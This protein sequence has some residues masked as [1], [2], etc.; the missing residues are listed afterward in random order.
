MRKAALI[1]LLIVQCH[2]L[3][4][5]VGTWRNYMSY[6]E[7]QQIVKAGNTLFVR[8]SN[9][10][11]QYN[12]EDQSITTYDKMTGLSDTYITHIGWNQ[13]T[14]RLII[15]YQNSNI[16][17]IDR[18]GNIT[19]IA[20]LYN[21]VI[22]DDKT[23][24]SLTIDGPYA[25]LYARFGIVKVNMQRAEI[26]DTYTKQHPNYPNNLPP[27]TV[28]A[29]W[30]Q[31]IDLVKTLKPEGPKYNYF[32]EMK[33][34]QGKLYTVG[35]YFVSG[36][37]DMQRPGIVQVWDGNNWQIYQEEINNITGYQYQDNNCIDLDPTDNQ[38]VIVGSRCGIYEFQN[39]QLLKYHNQQ[40]SLLKG[41][42]DNNIMLGNDYT[43]INGLKFDQEGNLWVLNSQ[44]KDVNL[45]ELTKEG[46]WVNHYQAKLA[47][48]NGVG[49]HVLQSMII[50]K[51]E[52]LWFVNNHW[53]QPSFY[54]Y[55]PSTD[56]LISYKSL[57]N[58]DGTIYNNSTPQCMMEDLD[59][60]IW[61]G[62][63][64]GPFIVKSDLS[65][66]T[67]NV[68]QVKIPRNDGS[69][70]ADYLLSGVNIRSM[71][72]DG[73]GR[74]WFGTQ[75]NGVYLISAD[76]MTQIYHFT[77]ENSALLSNTIESIAINN[78]T[79][80]VFF[81]TGNGLCSFI[82][83]A[84]QSA[85]T[86]DKNN[87]YAYPNPVTADYTGLITVVG[88]SL[89]ADVKI[90]SSSGKLIAEGRSNGGTFTWDGCDRNGNRV[91]S[92]VYMVIT[93]TND[94]KK[95]TVCKIAVIH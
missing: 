26:S 62:T 94:G 45:L 69:D 85:E 51:N 89:N 55:T 39:G 88:L 71:A 61:V 19:N 7:P 35:G 90:C 33:F 74:K 64:I 3:S 57:I 40:N 82:S 59:Y 21:K 2:I 86:M 20:A 38:H 95:G 16:D 8:A 4:A 27:S 41:A 87:I 37:A 13:E 79:G 24:D 73:G 44:A 77:A 67:A 58:Q 93:A 17:L 32:P 28:N 46:N 81:G 9:D 53:I 34:I 50:D 10:L 48:N 65:S 1:A 63:S 5:Q 92:G 78:A 56:E 80:E 29:D 60:N 36:G 70:Y 84:T 14:Q 11:Y 15:V 43:L 68:E 42:I 52:N 30:E 25:Y 72:I 31:Y 75:D 47:D 23:V 22:T 76:N 12:I 6:Y 18:N 54:R 91:A 49:L 83:N 66:T